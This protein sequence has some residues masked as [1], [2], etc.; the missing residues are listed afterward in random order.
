MSTVKLRFSLEVCGFLFFS[1]SPSAC[2]HLS[3][4]AEQMS[5][6]DRYT[7]LFYGMVGEPDTPAKIKSY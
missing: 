5:R 4:S 3:E 7:Y 6:V 1:W 2:V